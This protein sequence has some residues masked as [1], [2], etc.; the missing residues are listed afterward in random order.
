MPFVRA[1]ISKRLEIFL[2]AFVGESVIKTLA[3][4]CLESE[5]RYILLILLTI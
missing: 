2:A 4:Y 1:V 3:V 5:G